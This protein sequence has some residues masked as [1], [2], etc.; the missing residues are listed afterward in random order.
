LVEGLNKLIDEDFLNDVTELYVFAVFFFESEQLKDE[1]ILLF[2][3][4]IISKDL[5]L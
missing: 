4:F 1:E 5:F 3:P 2:L